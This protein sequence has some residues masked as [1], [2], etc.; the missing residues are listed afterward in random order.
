[1]AG[2]FNKTKTKA[3]AAPK[4]S[5]KQPT[6][7]LVGNTEA[8]K[9][10]ATALVEFVNQSHEIKTLQAKQELFGNVVQKYAEGQYADAYAANGVSPDTP[11]TIQNPD[12]VKA[13]FVMQDRGAQYGLKPAQL[14][15]LNDLLGADAVQNLIYEHTSFG[16]NGVILAIPGVLEAVEKS[17]E[18]T[19]KNL[20]DSETLTQD[21]CDQLLKAETKTALKPGTLSRLGMICGKDSIKISQFI[22]TIGSSATR[23]MKA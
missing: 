21:Q 3:V 23:Y 2:L 15:Q 7:W 11:M 14:D 12:G 9:P 19:F 17:L 5:T 4:E 13:T 16:F 20:V 10:V 6:V 1:M 8:T 18:K 22:D